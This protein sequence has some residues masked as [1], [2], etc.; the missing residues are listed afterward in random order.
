MIALKKTEGI[1]IALNIQEVN[2]LQEVYSTEVARKLIDEG[3]HILVVGSNE[4][5]K[6][7]PSEYTEV[8]D[9]TTTF[10]FLLG[11]TKPEEPAEPIEITIAGM[12][13]EEVEACCK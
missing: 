5:H 10:C 8:F 3:W 1:G 4:T 2:E 9:K 13:K 7:L 6:P 12:T 11:R